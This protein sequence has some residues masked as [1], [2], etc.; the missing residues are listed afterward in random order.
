M[1]MACTPATAAPAGSFSPI[2]RA[3]IAVVER[4]NPSPTAKTKLSRDSVRPTVAI[5][6]APRRP[7]QNTSTTAN[8]DSSTISR[9]MGMA[10][11][12]MA[13][14]ML[15]V[16]KSWC[17]SRNASRMEFHSGLGV[18]AVVSSC[19]SILAR[20]FL[21]K[22]GTP[23]HAAA[24]VMCR[25]GKGRS[26]WRRVLRDSDQRDVIRLEHLIFLAKSD[27]GI[28]ADAAAHWLAKFP[29][30]SVQQ[31]VRTPRNLRHFRYVVHPHDMR[32]P[33]NAGGHPLR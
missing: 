4:L 15:P 1:T 19:V 28:L 7:T 14:L 29:A 31:A 21:R 25:N 13:R 3:T 30:F 9:T 12:R 20:T 27:E 11:R 33:Q 17:E 18:V 32:S 24:K 8:R 26:A 10:S 23:A 2:R 5:A 22:R 16:V 6:S